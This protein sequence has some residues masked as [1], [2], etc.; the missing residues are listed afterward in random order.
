[1]NPLSHTSHFKTLPLLAALAAVLILTAAT[2]PRVPAQE[3]AQELQKLTARA[4]SQFDQ[5][6]NL[7]AANQA[8]KLYRQILEIKPDDQHAS[9]RLTWL[10]VYLGSLL[11]DKDQQAKY[12]EQATKVAEQGAEHHP[13]TPASRYW[14]G[15]AY[16]LTADCSGPFAGMCLVPPIKEEMEAL[17]KQAP[18][19]EYGGAYR[20]LGRLYT[21]LP[22]LLGGDLDKAEEYLRKAVELG[23]KF[24]LNHLYLANVLAEKGRCED[25]MKLVEMAAKGEPVPGMEPESKLWREHA[26]QVLAAVESGDSSEVV[27]AKCAN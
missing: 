8:V 23:P 26:N 21:K 3:P 19:Y 17:L 5:R 22:G 15:V 12:Y 14:L 9:V 24:W 6:E 11:E 2:A 16:G 27:L 4:D 13:N 18:D 10:L 20:I 1:M 7:Y 25:A